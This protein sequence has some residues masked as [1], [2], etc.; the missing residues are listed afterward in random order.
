M[1]SFLD[2]VEE[3]G[4]QAIASSGGTPGIRIMNEM[5]MF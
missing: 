1:G 4:I 5:L 2:C 3:E